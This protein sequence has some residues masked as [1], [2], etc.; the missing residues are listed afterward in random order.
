VPSIRA[1]GIDQTYEVVGAG[2]PLVMLHGATSSGSADFAAQLPRFASA[3]RCHLPDARG[4][5]ATRWDAAAGFSADMLADDLEAFADA[6]GLATFHLLGFSMGGMTALR[7]AARRPERVR[8]LVVIGITPEREPR[9]SVVRRLMDPDRIARDD[10]PWAVELASRLDPGQGE[11]AWRR[12]LPAIAADVASQSILSPAE[13]HQID[14]PALVVAGDR[15]PFCPVRHAADLARQ[16]AR[17]SLLIVP[18]CGHEVPSLRPGLL[19][20]ACGLFY[21]TTEA[22]ARRRAGL[23]DGADDG[24]TEES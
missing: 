21:R 17:A 7:F 1:N 2:P 24:D 16:L 13:L 15:D 23:D 22:V 6:I 12:L 19:N 18:D 14:A 9:A 11:G 3:F 10:P 5:G 20:E 8:T 4:H